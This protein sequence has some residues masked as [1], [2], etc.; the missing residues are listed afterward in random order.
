MLGHDGNGFV[1]WSACWGSSGVTIGVGD[2]GKLTL[3]G[4]GCAQRS[5][6]DHWLVV[7]RFPWR[8]YADI[9]KASGGH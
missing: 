3:I 2:R 9:I 6:S 1:N 7:A 5:G 4:R 8:E